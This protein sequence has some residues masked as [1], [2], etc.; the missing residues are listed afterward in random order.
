[1]SRSNRA[2]FGT[3]A[4]LST[5]QIN[6]ILE[7]VAGDFLGFTTADGTPMHSNPL[8]Q[9]WQRI[10]S[11][12]NTI[13]PV[14]VPNPWTVVGGYEGGEE[15]NAQSEYNVLRNFRPMADL[16]L[17]Y[18]VYRNEADAAAVCRILTAFGNI[19]GA[20]T[21]NNGSY[22][23]WNEWWPILIQAAN[24]VQD[25]PSYTT[26]LHNKLKST[27]M[28]LYNLLHVA[29]TRDKQDNWIAWGL[30]LEMAVAGFTNNR[31]MHDNAAFRWRQHF[32]EAIRNNF[33]VRQPNSP[34]INGR[35]NNVPINEVY[36]TDYDSGSPWTPPSGPNQTTTGGLNLDQ[37]TSKG[38]GG[39]GLLYSNHAL[40]GLI[41]A[42]EWARLDGTWLFD[43]T[44]PDGASVQSLYQA[45]SYQN[46]WAKGGPTP[47]GSSPAKENVCWYNVTGS[48]WDPQAA[49][50][51][52]AFYWSRCYGFTNL[53]QPIFPSA[54]GG[55]PIENGYFNTNAGSSVVD[56]TL[57]TPTPTEPDPEVRDFDY[58]GLRNTELIYRRVRF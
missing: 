37:Q 31:Q 1:M 50:G 51:Q 2:L 29:Y 44:S 46:R 21:E 28:L 27:T 39:R 19:T 32:A 30:S 33:L 13:Q 48:A 24:Y 4:Q 6:S 38:N 7:M 3:R 56:L 26:T 23:H 55:Y 10:M 54:E 40:N 11:R 43:F 41:M 8:R 25:S 16:A 15:T 49:R 34:A 47:G 57:V 14:N 12:D 17:R 20:D 45:I 9:K 42:A 53:L 5:A 58:F 22:L 35:R 18:Q 52:R 36:R